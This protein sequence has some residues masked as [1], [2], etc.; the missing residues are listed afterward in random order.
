MIEHLFRTEP[1]LANHLARADDPWGELV[2]LAAQ[3]LIT[4][5]LANMGAATKRFR[6]ARGGRPAAVTVDDWHAVQQI[7]SDTGCSRIGAPRGF[8]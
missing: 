7:Q 5:L 6:G 2:S 1:H 4:N 3:Q 8:R